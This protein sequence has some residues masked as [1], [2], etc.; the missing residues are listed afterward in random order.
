MGNKFAGIGAR[1]DANDDG[2]SVVVRDHVDGGLDGL[3]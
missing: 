2:F 3:N 1:L